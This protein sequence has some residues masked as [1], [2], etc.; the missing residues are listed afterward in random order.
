MVMTKEEVLQVAQ[1]ARLKLTEEE[2]EQYAQQLSAILQQAE[3]LRKLDTEGVPPTIQVLDVKN[4]MREDEVR[5]SPPLEAI[6][7]NAADHED[8]FFRVPAILE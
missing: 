6:L 1:L 7:Q 8:G 5:P 4:V 2:A 3:A